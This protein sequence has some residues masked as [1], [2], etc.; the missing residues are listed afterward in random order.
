MTRIRRR[1]WLVVALSTLA[2]LLAGSAYL[3]YD[4]LHPYDRDPRPMSELS[5]MIYGNV[6]GVLRATA[7][8]EV[9]PVVERDLR[10]WCSSTPLVKDHAYLSVF[11]RL[12]TTPE[13]GPNL[14][15]RAQAQLAAHPLAGISQQA[16]LLS[17]GAV[18]VSFQ[19]D[20]APEDVDNWEPR[21]LDAEDAPESSAM[22][23]AAGRPE[24]RAYRWTIPCPGGGELTTEEAGFEGVPPTPAALRPPVSPG[25]AVVVDT[26]SVYGF[27]RG[28]VSYVVTF[29]DAYTHVDITRSCVPAR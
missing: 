21:H 27:R 1:H 19:T 29:D 10:W 22:L 4:W 9:L 18:S 26:P 24:R 6:E 8:P 13:N 28:P 17:P 2:V 16:S 20:C 11:V 25:T 14:L 3:F 7:A 15:R 12:Y 5:A 23:A